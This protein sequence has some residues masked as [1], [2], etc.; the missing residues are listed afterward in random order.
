MSTKKLKLC[1]IKKILIYDLFEFY[2]SMATILINEQD[3]CAPGAEN[4][5]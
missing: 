5:K 2:N 4:M 1:F 3:F